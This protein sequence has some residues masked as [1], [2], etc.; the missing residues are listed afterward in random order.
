MAAIRER[1]Q[2]S[3]RLTALAGPA[4]Q[5]GAVAAAAEP[6]P[7]Y[8]SP[9]R[10]SADLVQQAC[11]YW[12]ARLDC[13]AGGRALQR[14]PRPHSHRSKQKQ[15]ARMNPA[16]YVP[17]ELPWQLPGSDGVPR[18]V[19]DVMA[20]GVAR[21]LRMCGVDAA[22]TQVHDI[23]QRH[24]IYRHLVE[25]SQD[26]GRVILTSDRGFVR[27]RYTDAVYLLQGVDRKAQLAEVLEV[28]R[29]TI[30]RSNLLSRCAKCNGELLPVPLA[31]AQLPPDALR[32]VPEALR[33]REGMAFWMCGRC[34]KVYWQGQQYGNAVGHLADRLGSKLAVSSG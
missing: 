19:C 32:H 24:Q 7:G 8:S 21:Q 23:S 16:G 27:G 20:E 9:G 2:P 34:S 5:Q 31:A 28:F 18:F 13:Q 15:A 4:E 33:E 25:S 29:L 17:S 10:A 12:A 26:E 11:E 6:W 22:S 14:G 3:A 30:E 1:K